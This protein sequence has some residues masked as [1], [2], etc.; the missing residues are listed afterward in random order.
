MDNEPSKLFNAYYYAHDCGEPYLRNEVWL[1]RFDVFAKRIHQDIRPA[2]VLDAGCALGLLVEVLRKAGIAAWGIDISEYAIQNVH[3]DIREYCQVGSITAPFPLPH[4]DL[5]VC[6]EVLEHLPKDEAEQAIANL[7]QHSNDILFSSTPID[8]QEA[9]HFNVQPAEYWVEYFARHGF[10]RDIDYDAAY[11]TPWAVRFRRQDTTLARLARGY[12]RIYAPL[13]HANNALRRQLI[14]DREQMVEQERQ[15]AAFQERLAH[16]AGL[17][18]QIAELG[19]QLGAAQAQNLALAQKLQEQE[20]QLANARLRHT[21]DEN[22][23]GQLEQERRDLAQ[24]LHE[25]QSRLN[26][27]Q[28]HRLYK[29][30]R[31]LRRPFK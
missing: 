28:Q 22:R 9:T 2:T 5:I 21:A 1:N 29:F 3:A 8:Y 14:V 25:T 11:I 23:L 10:F 20:R 30:I 18:G 7:C 15:S 24:Q 26:A 31:V 19:S 17:E 13:S 27:I 4:Y 16:S 6:I 12:E